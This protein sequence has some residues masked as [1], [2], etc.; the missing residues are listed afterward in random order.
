MPPELPFE[1]TEGVAPRSGNTAVE[2]ELGVGLNWLVFGFNV[3][4][5]TGPFVPAM[6]NVLFQNAG[7]A[8][9]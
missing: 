1:E 9:K 4:A 5:T 8:N 2:L 6:Y 3:N 7:V